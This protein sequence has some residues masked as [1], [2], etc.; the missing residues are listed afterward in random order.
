MW[1]CSMAFAG[2]GGRPA[3]HASVEKKHFRFLAEDKERR[4]YVPVDG[5]DAIHPWRGSRAAQDPVRGAEPVRRN[6]V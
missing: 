2:S 6:R 1:T 3:E 4:L 5:S